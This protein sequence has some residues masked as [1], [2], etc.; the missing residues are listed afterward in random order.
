MVNRLFKVREWRSAGSAKCKPMLPKL[1]LDKG[2]WQ[3][4][5]SNRSRSEAFASSFEGALCVVWSQTDQHGVRQQ[6]F[7]RDNLGCSARI[8]VLIPH[9]PSGSWPGGT[10]SRMRAM[11]SRSAATSAS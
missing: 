10:A 1:L 2:S 9:L 3:V 7:W 11:S 8:S 6:A 4:R 5:Q